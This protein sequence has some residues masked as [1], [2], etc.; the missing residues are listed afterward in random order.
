MGIVKNYKKM[1]KET[2]HGLFYNASEDYSL[3]KAKQLC[4]LINKAND[5]QDKRREKK[6]QMERIERLNQK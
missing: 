6:R 5:I 1:K 2:G 4:K 3:W